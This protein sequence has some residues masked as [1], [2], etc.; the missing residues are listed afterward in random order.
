MHLDLYNFFLII[1]R[2]PVFNESSDIWL[3]FI[4]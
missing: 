4:I 2:I 1:I 3:E